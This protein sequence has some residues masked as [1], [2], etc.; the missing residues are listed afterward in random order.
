MVQV[1]DRASGIR[2]TAVSA[3][4]IGRKGSVKVETNM[5]VTGWGEFNNMETVIA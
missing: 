5:G 2:V 1:E 4:P 3:I